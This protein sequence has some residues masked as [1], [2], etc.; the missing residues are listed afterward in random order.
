MEKGVKVG[1]KM[2]IRA[3]RAPAAPAPPGSRCGPRDAMLDEEPY[4]GAR[5][6]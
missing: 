3:I 6:T 1:L 5:D 4:F 2:G